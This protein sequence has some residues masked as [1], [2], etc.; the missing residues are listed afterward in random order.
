M[1]QDKKK[2]TLHRETLRILRGRDL[3]GARGGVPDPSD[4][5]FQNTDC[6]CAQTT[7]EMTFCVGISC[8]ASCN[9]TCP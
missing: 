1:R 8:G 2:L 4:V 5:Q 9:G 3:K 6:L 7:M